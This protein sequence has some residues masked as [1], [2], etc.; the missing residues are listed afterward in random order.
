[1]ADTGT[2]GKRGLASMDPE[3]AREI[4]RLGGQAAHRLGRAHRFTTEE[5]RKAGKK[6]GRSVSRDPSYM[7]EIG[8]RD[9][10]KSRKGRAKTKEQNKK[11]Q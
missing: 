7:A 1:M 9:G 6:G 5:A 11:G 2:K 4:H 10:E 8:R 3:K